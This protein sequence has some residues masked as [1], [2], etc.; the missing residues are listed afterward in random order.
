MN[1][2]DSFRSNLLEVL[3]RDQPRDELGR[4]ASTGGGPVSGSE[5]A[6]TALLDKIK[7]NPSVEHAVITDAAGNVLAE[8]SGSNVE[9]DIHHPMML[10]EDQKLSH[11]HYHPDNDSGSFSDGDLGAF[12]GSSGVSE[13][14][15]VLG[16]TGVAH[17]ITK[18]D[19]WGD[20]QWKKN[21]LTPA[22]IRSEYNME[23][24]RL[25]DTYPE[26]SAQDTI[27]QSAKYV[28]DKFEIPFSEVKI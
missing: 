8:S 20:S 19:G 17:V 5:V 26:M 27:Y 13:M 12:V 11:W 14:G 9:V 18:P 21:Q 15:V 10:E 28:V 7:Q 23:A 4:F 25:M 3:Y 24:D 1:W 22:K 2:I 6:Q 16:D